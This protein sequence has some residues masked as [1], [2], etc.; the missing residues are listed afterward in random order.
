MFRLEGLLVARPSDDLDAEISREMPGSDRVVLSILRDQEHEVEYSVH[1]SVK[2]ARAAP[3]RSSRSRSI[4][5]YHRRARTSPETADRRDGQ[6]RLLRPFCSAWLH[7]KLHA[8]KPLVRRGPVE[9]GPTALG[10]ARTTGP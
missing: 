9:A 2:A 10:D 1:D 8:V 4:G 6:R 5:G 3:S 7:D